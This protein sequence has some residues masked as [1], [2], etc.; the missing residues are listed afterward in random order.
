[1]ARAAGAIVGVLGL[2]WGPTPLLRAEPTRP[3]VSFPLFVS[4]GRGEA[5]RNLRAPEIEIAEG[6][7]AHKVASIVFR[8]GGSRR[9]GLFLDEYHVSPGASTERARASIARFV[10]RHL[11]ADDA[12]VV[13]KPLDSRANLAPVA[14]IEAA[15]E[16]IAGF[17]GRRGAYAPRGEFEAQYMSTAAPAVDRQRAQVVRAALE[18]LAIAMRDG[19]DAAK[20]LVIV[21]EGFR[22]SEPSRMRTT[23]LRAIARI[24]RLANIPVYIFDPSAEVPSASPLNEAWRAMSLE[25]GGVLFGAGSDLDAGFN[26]VAAD[27][28]GHYVV[29]FQGA[30]EDDGA[31]HGIEVKVKRTGAQARA[32]SGYWAPF[33]PS[34]FPPISATNPYANLL[35]PHVSGLIQP[36]FRM[37]PTSDGNTQITFSWMPRPGRKVTAEQVEF[38]ALTFEGKTLHTSTVTPLGAQGAM[39]ETTFVAPPGPLQV[40]MAIGASKLL[41]T[42]VRYIEV[43]RLDAARP[44]IAAVEFVR[45]RSLPEFNAM[46]TDRSAMPTETRQFLRQDHLLVRVR[47]FAASGPPAVKASLLNRNGQPLMDLTPL[48]PVGGAAQFELP[49]AR[50]PRGEYRLVIEATAGGQ[51]VRNLM[52][53]YVIG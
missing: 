50:F 3:L 34:R 14:N 49:F 18:S 46:R 51:T 41:D 40:S 53:I 21:T 17:E 47:A 19:G 23:T 39:M 36:W 30:A 35:T 9:V 37:A 13:M 11:R 7:T 4:D 45:P 1:M 8:G 48:A 31:F 29:E 27:L 12:L 20:A 16:A 32:P 22:S 42:D 10:E 38:K 52:T 15:H 25:T 43:P 44:T 33:G 28:G 5:V 26:R 24:A 2:L 6:G